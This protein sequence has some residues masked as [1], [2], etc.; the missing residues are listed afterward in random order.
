M[1]WLKRT[2][3]IGS[4]CANRFSPCGY[5]TSWMTGGPGVRSRNCGF[6]EAGVEKLRRRPFDSGRP[7]VS[8]STVVAWSAVGR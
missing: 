8:R 6:D 2:R 5:S 4:G 3:M 1:D 7:P